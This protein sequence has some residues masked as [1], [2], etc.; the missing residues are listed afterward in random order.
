MVRNVVYWIEFLLESKS[1]RDLGFTKPTDNWTRASGLVCVH[2]GCLL[3]VV[4]DCLS[5][6][7][8][9]RRELASERSC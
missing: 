6:E 7:T 2:R 1:V 5:G 4:A 9:R 3:G 8:D